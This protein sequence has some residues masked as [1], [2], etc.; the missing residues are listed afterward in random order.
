[1]MDLTSRVSEIGEL[2]EL[3]GGTGSEASLF[4]ARLTR[5][6]AS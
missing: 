3:Q 6:F 5:K 2:L 4:V 1:M